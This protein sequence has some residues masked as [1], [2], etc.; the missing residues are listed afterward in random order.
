MRVA[1]LAVVL[2]LTACSSAGPKAQSSFQPSATPIVVTPTPS[3]AP[4]PSL[5]NCSGGPSTAMAVDADRFLYDVSDPVHPRL[6]C[7]SANTFMHLLDGNAISYITVVA[8]QVVV[9]RH[10]LTSGAETLI[11][12][13]PTDPRVSDFASW[14]PDGSLEV[15]ASGLQIHLWSNGA[16]H[17]LYSFETHPAGFESRWNSPRGIVEFSPDHAYVAISDPA[18]FTSQNLRI[19]S[20]DDRRQ[21]LAIGTGYAQGGTWIANDRFV[22]GTG[23]VMQWT[24]TGGAKLLRSERWFG[25]TGSSDGRWLAATLLTD[26]LQPRVVIVPVG[27]GRTFVT[28]LGSSPGF[29]TP[30]VVWYAEEAPCPPSTQCG[31]DPTGPDRTVYAFD[32]TNGSD[33]V[34]HFRVGEEPITDGVTAL[35]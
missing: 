18:D 6:I 23:S 15:Y 27:A 20:V 7:R 1:V 13:L 17:L 21:V 35:A 16:D 3:P 22:W 29:V 28:G 19:F 10:D 31:A 32:V 26:T 8:R 25:A 11:A 34:V 14:T 4:T 2:I 9:V 33:Q 5:V 12:Q 30:T 24:P